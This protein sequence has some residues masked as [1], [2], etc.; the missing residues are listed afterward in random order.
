V[1]VLASLEQASGT[2]GF[3]IVLLEAMAHGL[4]IIAS[5]CGGIPQVVDNGR[6]ATL[7]EPGNASQLA[8]ALTRA[9]SAPDHNRTTAATEHLRRHYVW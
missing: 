4:P 6:V 2:E 5:R 3:G 7:V 1:L 8:A 9:A